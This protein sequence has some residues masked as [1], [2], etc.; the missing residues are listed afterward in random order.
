MKRWKKGRKIS[1]KELRNLTACVDHQ[2]KQHH[3][4]KQQQQQRGNVI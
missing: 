3:Q 1:Q 4:H 2:G